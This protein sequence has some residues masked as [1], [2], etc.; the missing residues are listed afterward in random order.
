MTNHQADGW[1]LLLV[2][3]RPGRIKQ[4]DAPRIDHLRAP[5]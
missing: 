5:F 1:N 2:E 3:I 4:K